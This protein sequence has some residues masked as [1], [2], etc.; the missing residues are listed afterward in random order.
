MYILNLTQHAATPE[1]RSAGVFDMTGDH[2]MTLVE[3]LTF[4]DL[5]TQQEVEERAQQIA[6]LALAWLTDNDVI[7][8][9]G[10]IRAMIGGAPFLMAP[11]EG[12]LRDQGITPVYAFSRRES[13]EERQSDGSIVKRTV[14]R[15]LGFVE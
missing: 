1:Q 8:T 11:L 9:V 3:L 6:E 14:F 7:D 5:P 4:N 13:V 2:L 15:H 12:A 10:D